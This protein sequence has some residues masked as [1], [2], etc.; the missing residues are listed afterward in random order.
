MFDGPAIGS[1]VRRFLRKYV[2]N[3][4]FQRRVAPDFV[5]V[6]QENQINLVL[7]CGAND[8]G[9]GREIRDRGYDGF[10]VS[11]EPNPDAYERLLKLI[12]GD[13]RWTAYPIALGESNGISTLFINSI[14]V[15]SSIKELNEFG[16]GTQAKVVKTKQVKISRLDSFMDDHPELPRNVYLKLDTQGFEMEILRGA[17][18]KLTEISIVQAELSLIHSYKDEPDWLDV[19]GWLRERE[20]ELVTAVCNSAVGARVREFD[21]VFLNGRLNR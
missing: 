2:R 17:G 18:S 3:F 4:G 14:D 1:V 9:F 13:E 8:G 10:I 21:F 16:R 6:M 20:F 11:F 15:M 19:I 12:R 5:D 7:D